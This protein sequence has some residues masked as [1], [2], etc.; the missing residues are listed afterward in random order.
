MKRLL[1]IAALAAGTC[2]SGA[3]WAGFSRGMGI[4]G[5]LTN[6]KRFNVLPVEHWL[7]ITVG[8]L[9][10]FD[11]YITECDVAYIA[12]C[13]FDHI[14]IGFDQIVLE[15]RPFAYRERTF[16]RLDDFVGWCA[17]HGVNVVL[18]LHKAVGNYCDI[19]EKV[20]L[21]DDDTLQRRVIALWLEIERRYHDRP[22]IAFELLNEVRDVDPAKWNA[23]ADRMVAAIREKNATRPIVV[24]STCWNSCW[25]LPRL[26][27]WDDPNVI[28]TFHMYEPFGFTHQRGVLQKDPLYYNRTLEYPTADV[29]RYRSYRELHGITNSYDGVTR[30]DRDYLAQCLKPAADFVRTHPDKVLWLGEFGTIRH[31]PPASRVAYMRDVISIAKE[32]GIPYCVWNYLSTPNDGNR[33]SL[34]DDDTRKF[35]SDEL[36]S[37]CLGA[38]ESVRPARGLSRLERLEALPVVDP[39]ARIVYDGSIA[40]DGSND[41]WDWGYYRD[42]HGEWVLAQDDGAGCIYNFTQHRYLKFPVTFR[43]Y[44]DGEDEPRLTVTPQEFGG[45]APFLRPLAGYFMPHGDYSEKGS[46]PFRIV[47]SFVPM[48]YEKGFKVTASAKLRGGHPGGWGHVLYHRYPDA[49]GLRTFTP[50]DPRLAALNVRY[51]GRTAVPHD[52]EQRTPETTLPAG[53]T[54]RLFDRKG[55]GV[56][57]EIALTAKDVGA[58]ALTN[59]W[60]ELSFDGKVT[61]SAPLGTFFGNE[62]AYHRGLV[63]TALLTLDLS[64]KDAK[65][66]NRFPMPYFASAAVVLVNRGKRAVC[67]GGGCVRVNTSLGYDPSVTGYFRAT[68]YYRAT[69]NAKGRNTLIGEAAG[70]GQIVYGVLS[71]RGIRRGCEGDVRLYLDNFAAPAVQSDGTESWGSWG[72]GFSGGLQCHPFSAYSC[73]YHEKEFPFHYREWSLQRIAPGDAYPFRYAFRFELEHGDVNDGGGLHSGQVFYYAK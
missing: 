53:G 19:P 62:C 67:L 29:G 47:R 55:R 32:H 60:V 71:G 3:E 73:D 33:F 41:D 46:R 68:P 23:L 21:L 56:L 49:R 42:E 50:D 43:F 70:C 63:E 48:E 31:A 1:F 6:Y 54:L 51:G 11:T 8:D 35:L 38:A 44:F 34:V 4:G 39:G 17:A 18:N 52:D 61:G 58:D 15:E 10:H 64:G 24:G 72:W 25:T 36:L 20:S 28:Y 59:V 16:R 45:K 66:S 27:V 30:I 40:H 57:T 2:A 69:P 9:E 13:G 7:P 14:R 37:A 22:G 65:C 5:W 12:S 26:K